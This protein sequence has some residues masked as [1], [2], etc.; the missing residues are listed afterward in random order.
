MYFRVVLSDRGKFY[1]L[2]QIHI[3]TLIS[4]IRKEVDIK[5]L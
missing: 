4:S 1:K 2:P 3:E 5:N